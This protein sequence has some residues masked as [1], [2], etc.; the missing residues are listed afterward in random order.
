MEIALIGLGK[1]GSNLAQNL[2][3]HGQ[4]VI[5]FDLNETARTQ[6]QELGIETASSIDEQL[7]RMHGKKI[8]WMML[9]SGKPT[10]DTILYLMDR[11]SK[12]DI[13]I[14]AGNSNY[15]DSMRRAALVSE[16]GIQYLD[17]GTSGGTSGARNGA[18]LMIGGPKEAYDYMADIFTSISVEKGCTYAGKSGAGHFMK[19]V[20]NGVEYGMMQAIGEGFQIMEE[21]EFGYDLQAVAENWNHGSVIRGWLMEIME[22]KFGDQPHLENYRGIVDASGEAKWTVETALEMEVPAPVI[23]LSL[24]M[25]NRSKEEDSFSGKV[26]AALRNG[27][28]GHAFVASEKK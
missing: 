21:S 6:L 28:G 12:G 19:M 4:T 3:D 9:P 27:F 24:M 16:K 17:V 22:E 13:L 25:R 11:M 18:C 8:V 1:M 10:E 5:G 14:E 2:K 7:G 26:V 15:K 23:A 20:H